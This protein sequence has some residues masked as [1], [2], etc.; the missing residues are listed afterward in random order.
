M[1]GVASL[2]GLPLRAVFFGEFVCVVGPPRRVTMPLC[3]GFRVRDLHVISV[4]DHHDVGTLHAR[5]EVRADGM[6][7]DVEENVVV[8]QDRFHNVSR[9]AVSIRLVAVGVILFLLPVLSRFL[10]CEVCGFARACER[11]FVQNAFDEDIAVLVE[12]SVL[13]V[14]DHGSSYRGWMPHVRPCFASSSLPAPKTTLSTS[15][16]S[17]TSPIMCLPAARTFSHAAWNAATG[18]G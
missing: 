5:E 8:I 9:G 7:E 10:F 4:V 14:G 15:M 18:S 12:V 11:G 3:V 16:D 6:L 17:V 13:V 1:G 2:R